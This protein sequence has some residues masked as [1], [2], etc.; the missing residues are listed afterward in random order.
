MPNAGVIP[1]AG[2]T[3]DVV[4][5]IARCVRD[6]AL[7][8]DALAGYTAADPKTVAGIGRRPKGGYASK[9]SET[10]LRGSGSASTGR[11]GATGRSRRRRPPSMSGRRG[12][13]RRAAP[14]WSRP[15]AGSG[16]A[17]IGSRAGPSTI[18]TPRIESVLF[19]LQAYLQRL[20]PDASLRTLAEFT[21]ATKAE[22]PFAK[23]GRARLDERCPSFA[24]C[25]TDPLSPP[26]L[27]TSWPRG[28]DTST[29]FA[30]VMDEHRLDALVFPQMRDT[31][32]P[33]HGRRRSMRRPSARSTSRACPA[34]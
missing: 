31:L 5:P 10:A 17:A 18:T 25:L 23:G 13:S 9:L 26:D 19:D 1:L 7:T 6:A 21:A 11:A 22:D 32:R 20:G 33:C 29:S 27:S 16:F 28:R 8:L 2:S 12:R 24:P 4:G 3:R 34:W 15:F 14:P 30:A